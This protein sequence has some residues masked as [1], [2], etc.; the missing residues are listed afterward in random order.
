MTKAPIG[1]LDDLAR[2]R[3]APDL[4]RA[5]ILVLHRELSTAMAMFNWFTVGVMAPSASE[6][7]EALRSLERDQNWDALE[8][9]Q[10]PEQSGPVYLKA[11]QKGGSIRIRIEHDLGC[12]ILIS[13]HADD[14]GPQSTTWGPLPLNFF[15]QR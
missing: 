7:L 2:L 4:D 1:R 5:E 12:G 15:Q 9:V 10:S 13:G 3:S 8:V 6:A 11:N 14:G